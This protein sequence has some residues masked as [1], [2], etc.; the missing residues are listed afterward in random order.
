MKKAELKKNQR[1]R[2]KIRRQKFESFFKKYFNVQIKLDSK[3]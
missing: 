3:F 2:N 1:E